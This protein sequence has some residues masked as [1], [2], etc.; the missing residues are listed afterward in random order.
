[1]TA[2]GAIQPSIGG[3]FNPGFPLNRDCH[4]RDRYV[5]F[6]S[7]PAARRNE[8]S[9]RGRHG[10]PLNLTHLRTGAAQKQRICTTAFRTNFGLLRECGPREIGYGPRC[11]LTSSECLA[12]RFL[13]KASFVASHP[14][15]EPF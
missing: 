10:K 6:T 15:K 9:F 12:K 13:Y 4:D 1:M 5:S 11:E 3:V 7:T 14:S 2:M 8:R